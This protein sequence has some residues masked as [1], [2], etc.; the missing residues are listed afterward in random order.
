MKSRILFLCIF[1]S[2]PLVIASDCSHENQTGAY[3]EC[4]LNNLKDADRRLNDIYEFLYSN[5]NTKNQKEQR[6]RQLKWIEV[7][8]RICQLNY[9]GKNRAGW[10]Q[11]VADSIKRTNCVTRLTKEREKELSSYIRHAGNT[12]TLPTKTL[13]ERQYGN[14]VYR[15]LSAVERSNGKWYFEVEIKYSEI[16]EQQSTTIFIGVRSKE[17]G[18]GRIVR[19]QGPVLHDERLIIGVA[20]NLDEGVLYLSENGVWGEMRADAPGSMLLKVGRK[21]HAVAE[22]ELA[23]KPL[24]DRGYLVFNS[25]KQKFRYNIPSGYSAYDR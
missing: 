6:S 21:Y 14:R 4:L 2:T 23:L 12:R 18:A 19:V 3:Q 24:L 15:Q 22:A 1:I 13:P 16:A 5:L 7:R 17:E 9:S 20:A 8:D 25:G 10:Y 11:Y